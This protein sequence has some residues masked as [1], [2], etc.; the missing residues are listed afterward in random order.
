[1]GFGLEM[2]CDPWHTDGTKYEQL[3]WYHQIKQKPLPLSIQDS[4][5]KR[6][7]WNRYQK[8]IEFLEKNQWKKELLLEYFIE[9]K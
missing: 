2:S 5:R 8:D 4:N 9:N 3:I 6:R 7:I 1:M